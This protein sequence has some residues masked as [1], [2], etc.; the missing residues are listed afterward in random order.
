M[1]SRGLLQSTLESAKYIFAK[2]MPQWP[3]YY[4]LREK[5][6]NPEVSFDDAMA[7]LKSYSVPEKWGHK[8]VHYFKAGK[9]RYW[10]MSKK[11][12]DVI[13]IN[14]ALEESQDG[15]LPECNRNGK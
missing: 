10:V 1:I 9:Y 3:H 8:I 7:T 2:T 12:S 13:L 5:W 6:T 15:N 11:V 4:T 14:R